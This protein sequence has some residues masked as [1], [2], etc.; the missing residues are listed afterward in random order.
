M[1]L[2]HKFSLFLFLI[3]LSYKLSIY[4][5]I[6]IVSYINSQSPVNYKQHSTVGDLSCTGEKTAASYIYMYV[7]MYSSKINPFP[8]LICPKKTWRGRGEFVCPGSFVFL[9]V[10]CSV[11]LIVKILDGPSWL[12]IGQ[13]KSEIGLDCP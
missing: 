13:F 11:W 7:C 6:H 8:S 1:C 4:R 5:Y 2:S 10:H 12:R 9:V 3:N